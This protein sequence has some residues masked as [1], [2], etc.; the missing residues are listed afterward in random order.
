MT[1]RSTS[2]LTLSNETR[3]FEPGIYRN[4]IEL[5]NSSVALLRP[6]IYVFEGGGLDVG[7]Q[8]KVLSIS[9]SVSTPNYANWAGDCPVNLCGVMLYNTSGAHAMGPISIAAGATIKL[10]AYDPD[11][12]TG[13]GVADF[14]NILIWQAAN[15]V[16]TNSYAQP[17]LELKG[18]GNIDIRGTVYAPSAKVEMGGNSGGS[19]GDTVNVTLQFISWDLEFRGNSAFTFYF[20]DAEFVRPLDYGLVE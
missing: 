13:G 14:E 19:G 20:N 16:P 3:I 6:G 5:R 2:H 7:S 10:R 8:A 12:L 15:P 17:M 18:G 9:S 4:G 1:V 11:A